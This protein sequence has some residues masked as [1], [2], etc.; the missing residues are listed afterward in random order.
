MSKNT[1]YNIKVFDGKKG[2]IY[3]HRYRLYKAGYQFVKKGRNRYYELK[4]GTPQDVKNIKQYCRNTGLK[5]TAVETKFLRSNNYRKIFFD[6]HSPVFKDAYFCAYCGRLIN[7][8]DITV[9]HLYPVGKVSKSK[10]MQ[11]MLKHAGYKGVNDKKN[12]VPAC[13]KCN[14]KKSANMGWWIVKGKVGKFQ[15]L[16]F[17]RWSARVAVL[18][19]AMV[20]LYTKTDTPI[21]NFHAILNIL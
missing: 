3:Y 14:Q 6:T 21:I 18:A 7:K 16:W 12:L 2:K 1:R 11:W 13:T 8:K 5:Y 4:N 15:K 20:L 17:A 10:F 19:Y 9:D